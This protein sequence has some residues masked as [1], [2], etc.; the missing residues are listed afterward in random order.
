MALALALPV[1]AAELAGSEWRPTGLGDAAVPEDAGL[2]L[3][4]ESDGRLSGHSGCNSFFGSYRI[5]DGMIEMGPFGST[6]MACEDPAMAREAA[7]LN[8]LAAVKT[9]ER[10]GPR[11]TLGDET[12]NPLVLLVQTDWD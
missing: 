6:R 9:F 10:D 8:A 11:L 1:A 3:R 5:E 12:G 4:F 2:F 7:F